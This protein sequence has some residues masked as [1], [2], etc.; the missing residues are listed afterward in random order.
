MKRLACIL[1]TLTILLGAFLFMG[2]VHA[3]YGQVIAC[4]TE[5]TVA[6][7]P[8]Q[9]NTTLTIPTG[10]TL[11][12]DAGVTVNTGGYP[13]VVYGTLIAQG[14]AGSPITIN[15]NAEGGYS[16]ACV[17]FTEN[18]S[19]TIINAPSIIQ[20]AVLNEVSVNIFLG[21]SAEVDSCTFNF[22]F[23]SP[24]GAIVA[25]QTADAATISNNIFN[26]NL[27]NYQYIFSIISVSAGN[28]TISN[29]QFQGSFSATNA[30][31][32]VDSGSPVI[33]GNTFSA[34]YCNNSEGVKV[35]GGAPQISSNQFQGG[36][37]LNAVDDS[38]PSSFTISNN[39]FQDCNFG[40]KAQTGTV[41]TVQG[42]QFLN[43]VNGVDIDPAALVTVTDN[44][45][46][47]NSRYGING[48]GTITSN[49]ISNNQVGI[50]NPPSGIISQNNIVGNTANS[51]TA[52]TANINAQNNWWGTTDTA[53]I[54]QTIYDS[55]VDSHLGTVSYVPFLTAPS[56]TAPAIPSGTPTVT[57]EPTQTPGWSSPTTA[58]ASTPTPTP[59]KYSQTFDYQVGSI[60]NLNLITAAVATV[61]VLAWAIVILGYVVKGRIS[62]YRQDK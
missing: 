33:S 61:L 28:P 44:L 6:Q 16:S 3:Q 39:V 57:A 53:A 19:S 45:I 17:T 10:V 18:S 22:N 32:T 48:G 2:S 37:Y 55:K 58:P 60:F 9:L 23:G 51:I 43:G 36:G 26:A 24:Y 15:S 29:N 46:N 49:T 59:L 52:T 5:W 54:N 30:A 14:N 20:N 56:A 11:T 13:F 35:V 42:N 12:I 27:Q 40:V 4:N 21:T 41:L 62:K 47:G 25:V 8:I 31:I 7:S 34:Q 38:S 50:H 1:L